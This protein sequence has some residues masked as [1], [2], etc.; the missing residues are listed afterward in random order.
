MCH[1]IRNVDS[2]MMYGSIGSSEIKKYGLSV[3][4]R[5]RVRIGIKSV[6]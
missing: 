2:K 3:G 1:S 4:I 5:V 6:R